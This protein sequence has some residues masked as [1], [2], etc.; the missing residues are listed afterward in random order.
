MVDMDR[1]GY[2]MIWIDN[3]DMDIV[4]FTIEMK[5]DC[6]GEGSGLARPPDKA[7][8]IIQ[9]H[10]KAFIV[11]HHKGCFQRPCLSLDRFQNPLAVFGTWFSRPV[12]GERNAD[13][14]HPRAAK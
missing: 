2:G 14:E 5:C 6:F 11:P 4:E 8:C 1:Y 13:Q 12:L 3:M 9:T 10:F 7:M